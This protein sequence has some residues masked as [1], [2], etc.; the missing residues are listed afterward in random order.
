MHI[1][2]SIHLWYQI[3]LMQQSIIQS[4]L[5]DGKTQEK[6]N[7]VYQQIDCI[8]SFQLNLTSSN[9]NL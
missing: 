2:L 8:P 1:Y 7:L 3:V 5:F 6:Q 4:T 9:S